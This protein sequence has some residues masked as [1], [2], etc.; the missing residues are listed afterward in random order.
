MYFQPRLK[1]L[2]K[3]QKDRPKT[4]EVARH[5]TYSLYSSVVLGS[6]N[7]LVKNSEKREKKII[8]GF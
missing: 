5:G 2:V 4:V 3:F 7:A 8:S 6:K 1:A